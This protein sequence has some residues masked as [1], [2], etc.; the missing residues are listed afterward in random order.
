[1]KKIFVLLL[2][3]LIIPSIFAINVSVEKKSSDETMIIGLENPTIFDLE[4]TN[5]DLTDNFMFYTFF[6]GGS[7]PQETIYIGKSQTKEIEFGVYPR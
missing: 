7:Y 5:H 2:I 4:V 1:M 6:G 3:L